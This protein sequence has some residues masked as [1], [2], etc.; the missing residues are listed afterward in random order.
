MQHAT[1]CWA[2]RGTSISLSTRFPGRASGF[3]VLKAG[4]D[5]PVADIERARCHAANDIKFMV[6]IGGAAAE[7][8]GAPAVEIDPLRTAARPKSRIAASP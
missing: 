8:L 1:R 2:T 5:R 6:A 7:E 4:V 3:I